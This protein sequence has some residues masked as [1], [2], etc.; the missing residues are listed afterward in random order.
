MHVNTSN[1]TYQV[2]MIYHIQNYRFAQ[3]EEAMKYDNFFES[4]IL[5]AY[6]EKK[7]PD[8]T[9]CIDFYGLHN[10]REKYDLCLSSVILPYEC[11]K[12]WKL[13]LRP[14]EWNILYDIPGDDIF[15]YDLS[16]VQK[17]RKE[18][19]RHH[20]NWMKYELKDIGWLDALFYA[21]YEKGILR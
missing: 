7:Y 3:Y 5:K 9:V 15:L 18:T 10:N 6:F 1:P 13:S 20:Y 12:S 17:P 14:L 8:K 11:L 4:E 21:L 16:Y 19:K 2:P